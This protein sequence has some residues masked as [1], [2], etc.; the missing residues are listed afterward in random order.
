[1]EEITNHNEE[2]KNEE[3]DDKNKIYNEQIGILP[4]Y[5]SYEDLQSDEELL[6]IISV[7]KGEYLDGSANDDEDDYYCDDKV[8]IEEIVDESDGF[9]QN[10]TESKAVNRGIVYPFEIQELERQVQGISIQV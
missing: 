2:D 5:I 6:L 1:M 3:K 4:K 9:L 10:E 8:I 7:D